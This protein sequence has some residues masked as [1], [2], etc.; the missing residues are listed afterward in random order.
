MLASLDPAGPYDKVRKICL[1][2]ELTNLEVARSWM[3]PKRKVTH[4][5]GPSECTINIAYGKIPEGTEPDL[6]MLN[7]GVEVFLVDSN[8]QESDVGEILI[9]GWSV[10]AGYLN[11]P[12]LTAKKF[13]DWN[14]RRVYRTGDV[15]KRT[16]TGLSWVGR[17]DRI[18][19]NRGYL[20]NLETEV[21]TAMLRFPGVR[22]SSA[23]MWRDRLMGFVQPETVNVEEM[24][25]FLKQNFDPF[26]VPD[27]ILALDTFPVTT[28][29]KVDRGALH[30]RLEARMAGEDA[31]LAAMV[32]NSPYDGL[33]WAFARCLQVPLDTLDGNSS[34]SQLGGNSLAAMTLA[35][36]LR[37]Q[38]YIIPILQIIRGDTIGHLESNL[39]VSHD[40]KT[41]PY[42]NGIAQIESQPV[43][44]TDMHRLMLTQSQQ[45]PRTNCLIARAK[46]AGAQ[47]LVP[48]PGELLTAWRVTLEAHSI[49]KTFYDLKSWTLHDLDHINLEWEEVSVDADEFDSALASIDEQI[50]ERHKKLPSLP[51]SE[52]EVPYCHMTCVYAPARKAIGFVWRIHHV[53]TDIFSF[54]I[55]LHDLEKA[56]AKEKLASGPLIRE[57]SLFMQHY[58]SEKLGTATDFWKRMMEPL[59]EQSLFD[60]RPPQ[61]PFHS[62][63]WCTLNFPTRETVQSI[64]AAVLAYEVSSA[65]LIFAAWALTL[66][67]YTRFDFVSLYLSRSGRMVPWP[68]APSLVG[69]LNCRVPFATAVPKR[70]NVHKWLLAMH[71][72]L[73]SVAELE[74]L[75]QSL[76]TSI[77]PA[78][79]FKTGVQAFLYMPQ[80][81][82]TWKV[83]DKLTGQAEPIGMVWRVQSTAEGAVEA[84]L[85]IDQ[86][87]VD[88]EWAREVG[89]VAVQMLE[90]LANSQKSTTLGDL[91][92]D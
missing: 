24:R 72:K 14:G 12:E 3:T 81:P 22:A 1:G 48:T 69:A 66:S 57:Y 41:G 36:L 33:R 13:I 35:K 79:Y 70:A 61:T 56:L 7:P 85:E 59:G 27:E 18:V 58:K 46:F 84:E 21:E 25:A 29:A 9:G 82:A 73:D 60:F 8:L 38:G 67:K 40:L 16:A 63:D 45:N 91:L 15:A 52:L 20:V 28:H 54:F 23:F 75:C 11:N 89:A 5:Y 64:E 26:V 17:A 74:N 68:L 51:S 55:L 19:K 87:V 30:D 92:S 86:R 6:G 76:D 31:K 32:C 50:W 90:G 80:S 34:F 53:L 4:S 47:D 88:V 42:S 37:Q 65:T 10:G 77:Y 71:S 49:F 44:A 43:R 78:E 62:D 2:S 83:Y 39:T